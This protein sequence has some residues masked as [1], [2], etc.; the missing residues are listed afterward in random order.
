M[1]FNLTP[2]AQRKLVTVFFLQFFIPV[3]FTFPFDR[4]T[5]YIIYDFQCKSDEI[6]NDKAPWN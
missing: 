5:I 4:K 6:G 2:N 1:R 3:L